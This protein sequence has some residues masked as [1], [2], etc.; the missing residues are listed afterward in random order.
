LERK[1]LKDQ[2]AA[3]IEELRKRLLSRGP[4]LTEFHEKDLDH[5]QQNDQYVLLFLQHKNKDMEK[6]LE[7]MVDCFKWRKKF[8]INDITERNIDRRLFEIGFLYPH[9]V[10]KND[11]T[12]LLF[13]TKK[14]KKDLWDPD[15]V[16]KLFAF[17]LEK[18]SISNPGKKLSMVFDM[19]DSTLV[20]MDLELIKFIITC[21]QSY[22]PS[23]LEYMIIFE[24]PWI[25][26]APWKYMKTLLSS[27]ALFK[28]KFVNKVE[29]FNY[30]N[31]DQLLQTMGGTD[32][33]I[34]KYPP[35][36]FS[37]SKKHSSPPPLKKKTDVFSSISTSVDA[38]GALLNKTNEKNINEVS[39]SSIE[40][41]FTD[42]LPKQSKSD[43]D[44]SLLR[45]LK[46][47]EY[48][49]R[50]KNL[51]ENNGPL[52]T[53]SPA[54]ELVFFG[55]AGSSSEL[56]QVITIT[57]TISSLIAFKI[58]TTSPENF[59]VRPSSGPISPGGTVEV[60]VLLQSTHDNNVNKDRFLILSTI[61]PEQEKNNLLAMWKNIP[62]SSIMEQRLRCRFD[63]SSPGSIDSDRESTKSPNTEITSEELL[64]GLSKHFVGFEHKIDNMQKKVIVL[65][66]DI[67][68]VYRLLMF[69]IFIIILFLLFVFLY[70]TKLFSLAIYSC[71]RVD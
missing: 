12:L 49:L 46:K 2:V 1:T 10:D 3:D 45:N 28:I 59:R 32:A 18:M 63:S 17:A 27:D 39:S 22:F 15:E 64:L 61:V 56:L 41:S 31:Q 24:T 57:N 67:K 33:Y 34:Y 65:E 70:V 55:T 35:Q 69:L 7:M 4:E 40:H 54:H 36:L 9:N 14:Y 21:F 37:S 51:L 47:K 62:K 6:A 30:V 5:V 52:I 20:N 13:H 11:N 26:T 53:I 8:G 16:K 42:S 44:K 68:I 58:K 48:K 66:K 60:Q 29:I 19:Q 43:A 71:V 50:A 25:L 23:M 38:A